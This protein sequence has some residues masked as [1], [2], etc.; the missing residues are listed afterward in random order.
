[1]VGGGED[2]DNG[3]DEDGDG[4]DCDDVD[5]G[6]VGGCGDDVD[7]AGD[8]DCGDG[9]DDDDDEGDDDDG[10]VVMVVIKMMEIEVMQLKKTKACCIYKL[11]DKGA[12]G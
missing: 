4:H 9:G 3:A 11:Y 7:D 2:E 8:D 10:M 5:G 1:M 12:C 6:D